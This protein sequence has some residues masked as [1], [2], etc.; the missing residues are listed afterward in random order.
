MNGYI[1]MEK[2]GFFFRSMMKT[3]QYVSQVNK[4]K[5]QILGNCKWIFKNNTW[6]Y[7][8]FTE[9]TTAYMLGSKVRILG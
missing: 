4:W 5:E 2:K 9:G 3:N 8:V 1:L 6:V 7:K